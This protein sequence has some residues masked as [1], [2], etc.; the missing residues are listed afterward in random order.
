MDNLVGAHN[1][2]RK[3]WERHNQGEER[4]LPADCAGHGLFRY[5]AKLSTLISMM[6]RSSLLIALIVPSIS[7][8]TFL[9]K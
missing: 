7:G 9:M 1:C 6:E 5:Q 3:V 2:E 4:K 8:S